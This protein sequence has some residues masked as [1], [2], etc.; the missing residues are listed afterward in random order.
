MV[1]LWV[2]E[3]PIIQLY[4]SDHPAY[5]PQQQGQPSVG[6]GLSG[7]PG[8][9]S[10]NGGQPHPAQQQHEQPALQ[11][12]QQAH[13]IHPLHSSPLAPLNP[14]IHTNSTGSL[15]HPHPSHGPHPHAHLHNTPNQQQQPQQQS[16]EP[17]GTLSYV[18][19]GGGGPQFNGVVGHQNPQLHALQANNNGSLVNLGPAP[20]GHPMHQHQTQQQV[21]PQQ[22][23]FQLISSDG[24]PFATRHFALPP[25]FGAPPP[26]M[27]L[28]MAGQ[29]HPGMPPQSVHQQLLLLPTAIPPD[30]GV[31]NQGR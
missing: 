2:C 31:Y 6:H 11:E 26:H 18:D 24:G 29:G 4:I 27:E 20:P 7:H 22:Q 15:A 21:Q 16:L 10:N 23:Q 30:G 5:L 3:G 19:I 14:L 13:S 12:L 17:I 9:P 1:W 28:M 8:M 25:P